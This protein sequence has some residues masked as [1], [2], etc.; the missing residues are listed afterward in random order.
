[1]EFLTFILSFTGALIFLFGLFATLV[2]VLE[3]DTE[4]F[5]AGWILMALGIVCMLVWWWLSLICLFC[6]GLFVIKQ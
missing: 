2:S 3:S 6:F 4:V 5:C 1:M